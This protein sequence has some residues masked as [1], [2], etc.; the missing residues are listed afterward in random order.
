[1]S[2]FL[3]LLATL[4][5]VKAYQELAEKGMGGGTVTGVPP[6]RLTAA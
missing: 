1:M 5:G 6:G 3:S 4:A 2:A